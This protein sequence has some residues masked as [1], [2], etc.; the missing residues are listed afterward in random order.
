[1]GDGV[2]EFA[3]DGSQGGSDGSSELV[4]S[5]TYRREG[6]EDEQSARVRKVKIP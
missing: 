2:V 6:R 4:P 3:M 1:V 5:R